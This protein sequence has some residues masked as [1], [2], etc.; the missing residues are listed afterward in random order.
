[1]RLRLPLISFTLIALIAACS[2]PGPVANGANKITAVPAE[3]NEPE[4]T[5]AGG[6]PAHQANAEAPAAPGAP[7][8]PTPPAAPIP[9]A[10]QGRWGLTPGD[11][12]SALGDAKGLLVVNSDE[13]RFYE[14]RAVPGADAQAR[15]SSIS[16]TFHFTGE[17]QTWSRFETLKRSADKLVRTESNPAASYTYARC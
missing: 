1:M 11:C 10:L 2:Q 7:T 16:G 5:P 8:A 14:S 13:L 9:A 3:T 4:P 12:T 17:G 6:P 15:P